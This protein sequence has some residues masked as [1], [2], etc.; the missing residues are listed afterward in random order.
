MTVSVSHG[1]V[2]R[3]EKKAAKLRKNILEM[4]YNANAGHPGGSLSAADIVT[5][6]Y[7]KEL[8]IDPK[9]PMKKDR[10]RFILSKGHACPVL[11]AALAMRGYFDIGILNTLRQLG[12]ILQGHPDMKKVPGVDMTTGSLGQGLSIGAGIALGLKHDFLNSRVFVMLGDGELQ[13]GQIWEAAMFSSKYKLDNLIAVIDYNNL[14]LDG[15]CSDIMPLEPLSMKWEAFGWKVF[16]IDGHD[17]G[18]IL[19]VFEKIKEVKNKPVCVIAKT[20]KGKGVSYMENSCIWHGIVPDQKQFLQAMKEL[21][22]MGGCN[23]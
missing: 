16:D 20:I 19:D 2:D 11:Y 21:D 15:L 9:D 17:I 14:Q 1:E 18:M 8:N 7:F 22:H 12:S 23:E 13:E 5:V 6:L 3:L 10:D 4:I